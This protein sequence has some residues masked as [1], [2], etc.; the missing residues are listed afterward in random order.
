MYAFLLLALFLQSLT[1]CTAE[2][3]RL[4]PVPLSLPNRLHPATDLFQIG[5][6]HTGTSGGCAAPCALRLPSAGS[7][8]PSESGSGRSCLQASRP[9]T[10]HGFY[11]GLGAGGSLRCGRLRRPRQYHRTCL[12]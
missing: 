12:L 9:P 3:P 6:T 10:H 7:I 4:P 8:G 2:S 1:L 5:F 11:S